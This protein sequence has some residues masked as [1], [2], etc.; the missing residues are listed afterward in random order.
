MHQR[1]LSLALLA[2]VAGLVLLV[3][4]CH[5]KK[6]P[7]P[8]PPAPPP[9]AAPAP[10]GSLTAEP[11]TIEKGQSSTLSWTSENATDV[12]LQ[13]NVGTVQSNGSTTV[14]PEES[15][16]YTLTVKGAGGQ[17]TYE[18]RV[19]VTAP[20]PAPAPEQAPA[21]SESELFEQNVK[22][23]YFDFNKSDIRAD[24]QQA[25][26]ADA[27]F[28]K[29]HPSLTFT[30]EGHCDE[31]GTEEYNLGLGDRRANS[32]K[33]FLVNLGVAASRITT[34]SYG[35]DRPFCTEHTEECWQQ[36]RRAHFVLGSESK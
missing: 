15:T 7:P 23:A 34:I 33:E 21:I 5:K 36:N 17:N 14:S 4:S 35:K 28:F 20:P 19:T 22:D 3:A 25:L 13:P 10:T 2:G 8:A 29:G 16:T 31:R 26:N 27:E 11:S 1:K 24:A 6:V 30:I 12:E 18:A 32:V 9:A